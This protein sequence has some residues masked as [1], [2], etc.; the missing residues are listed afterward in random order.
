MQDTTPHQVEANVIKAH[1]EYRYK[2]SQ[3]CQ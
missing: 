2:V 1:K 3:K